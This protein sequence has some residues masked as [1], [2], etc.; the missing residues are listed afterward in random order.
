MEGE[1]GSLAEKHTA[2]ALG[3]LERHDWL[4]LQF[5]GC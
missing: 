1:F 3:T 4:S 2:F 5:T